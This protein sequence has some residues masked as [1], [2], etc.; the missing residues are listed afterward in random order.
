[1]DLD[2]ENTM[3]VIGVDKLHEDDVFWRAPSTPPYVKALCELMPHRNFNRHSTITSKYAPFTMGEEIRTMKYR[4]YNTESIDISRFVSSVDIRFVTFIPD[5]PID[6]SWSDLLDETTIYVKEFGTQQNNN[7]EVAMK[8]D[9]KYEVSEYSHLISKAIPFA[10]YYYSG[11]DLPRIE[12]YF[13]YVGTEMQAREYINT[14]SSRALLSGNYQH[15]AIDAKLSEF[16]SL[17]DDIS[18]GKV[19]ISVQDKSGLT[20]KYESIAAFKTTV[21]SN[22]FVMTFRREKADDDSY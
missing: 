15:I 16:A 17:E 2:K 18:S 7:I 9:K 5:C 13:C 4:P 8:Q 12:Q 20:V 1:M 19:K 21:V 6:S 14:I 3:F 22:M 10:G 11:I